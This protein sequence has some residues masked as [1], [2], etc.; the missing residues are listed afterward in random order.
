MK[1]FRLFGLI[2]FYFLICVLTSTIA[3]QNIK[4]NDELINSGGNSYKIINSLQNTK[5]RCTNNLEYAPIGTTAIELHFYR[6]PKVNFVY[7][8]KNQAKSEGWWANDMIFKNKHI[9]GIAPA[10][11]RQYIPIELNGNKLILKNSEVG[12]SRPDFIFYRIK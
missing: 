8:K 6:Y 5:W 12:N 2:I 7:I 10:N 3:A 1:K 9:V 4:L 11:T